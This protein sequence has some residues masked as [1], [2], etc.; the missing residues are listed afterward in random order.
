MKKELIE[1][2]IKVASI[3]FLSFSNMSL[4]NFKLPNIHIKPHLH[5]QFL[6]GG[7]DVA[8]TDVRV[9]FVQATLVCGRYV[10]GPFLQWP[11]VQARTDV[12]VTIC[13]DGPNV[14]VTFVRV[15]KLLVYF[16]C[17]VT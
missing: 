8:P 7:G 10:W 17:W 16:I 2:Y 9:N 4:N 3:R 6:V 14:R 12:Q 13:P 1:K 15:K 5:F 11:L